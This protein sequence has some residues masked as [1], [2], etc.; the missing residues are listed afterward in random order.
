MSVEEI[1]KYNEWKRI[2]TVPA[3]VVKKATTIEGT[4]YYIVVSYNLDACREMARLQH[5]QPKVHE[6]IKSI[7]NFPIDYEVQKVLHWGNLEKFKYYEKLV[8][9]FPYR[10]RDAL[11][12][13]EREYRLYTRSLESQKQHLGVINLCNNPKSSWLSVLDKVGNKYGLILKV[14]CK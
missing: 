8:Y 14:L 11:A 13:K 12:R 3:L 10:K 2:V 6:A 1:N 5:L 4:I 9:E 7:E